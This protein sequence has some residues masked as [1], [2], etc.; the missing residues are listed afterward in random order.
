[1]AALTATGGDQA[2][3]IARL[4]AELAAAQRDLWRERTQHEASRDRLSGEVV[5]QVLDAQIVRLECRALVVQ[6][7]ATRE[8]L[9]SLLLHP[10]HVFMCIYTSVDR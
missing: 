2:A 5:R 4:Q 10:R 9:V 1:M 7:D 6:R 8:S 3:Q